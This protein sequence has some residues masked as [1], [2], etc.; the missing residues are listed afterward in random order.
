M[1]FIQ[2]TSSDIQNN[3]FNVTVNVEDIS[4]IRTVKKQT[5]INLRSKPDFSVWSDEKESVIL[6]RLQHV[7]AAIER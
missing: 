5:V 2:V 7:G 3:E 6:G 4:T 1:R